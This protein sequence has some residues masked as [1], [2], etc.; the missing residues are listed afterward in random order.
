MDFRYIAESEAYPIYITGVAH[1]P[2]VRLSY[3]GVGGITLESAT[4][5]AC[6]FWRTEASGEV[7]TSGDAAQLPGSVALDNVMFEFTMSVFE[8]TAIFAKETAVGIVAA[9]D[10]T[11]SRCGCAE[12]PLTIAARHNLVRNNI[13]YQFLTRNNYRPINAFLMRY[14]SINQSW[15]ANYHYR[16][17]SADANTTERWDLHYE[18]QCVDEMGATQLGRNIWKLGISILRKNLSTL[19]DYDT[20]I[21]V[22]LMPETVCETNDYELDFTVLLDTQTGS[23]VI[24]P[25]STIYQVSIYDN[26]GLFRNV[27]WVDN[28][29]FSITV[30]QKGLDALQ[31]RVDLT[32]LVYV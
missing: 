3:E 10:D 5:R 12:I 6:S 31:R 27:Y 14:N 17:L 26:I 28:P 22:A 18:L 30:S 25:P 7:A 2:E 9:A 4:D 21:I 29:D 23:A 19:E 20:R 15:Q 11:L 16:G 13:F 24:S 1:A 8:A 32:D